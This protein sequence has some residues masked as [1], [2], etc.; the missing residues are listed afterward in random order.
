MPVLAYKI[1]FAE[2]WADAER[3][4]SYVGSA[5]DEADGYIHLSTADQVAETLRRYFDGDP[6]LLLVAVDLS[7]LAASVRW[8]AAR[9]GQLFPHIYG[10]LPL[11]AVRAVEPIP[12]EAQA[13][14]AFAAQLASPPT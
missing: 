8:E 10:E 13:R 12:N 9:S 5:V 4:G 14:A 2:E 1:C 7:G 11:S 3:A 6:D